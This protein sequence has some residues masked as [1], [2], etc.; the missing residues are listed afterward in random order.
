MR[1]HSPSSPAQGRGLSKGITKRC[2]E[3]SFL[4][5]PLARHQNRIKEAP[6]PSKSLK[7]LQDAAD[8][9]RTSPPRRVPGSSDGAEVL[10]KAWSAP[11]VSVL[12]QKTIIRGKQV[13][14]TLQSHPG[15]GADRPPDTAG[16]RLKGPS[17][18]K[19]LWENF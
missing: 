15:V 16:N 10:C 7:V 1:G 2:G 13:T 3:S 9:G 14:P 4:Q 18:G 8:P 12:A 19:H 5:G 17:T 6:D 11:R